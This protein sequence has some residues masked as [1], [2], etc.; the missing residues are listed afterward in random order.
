MTMVA[1]ARIQAFLALG[2]LG[3]GTAHGQDRHLTPSPN[4][5]VYTAML[6]SHLRANFDDIH[7]VS[8]R[9]H[10]RD[11]RLNGMIV[12]DMRWEG[13]RMTSA[14]VAR[15]ETG[16]R[17]FADAMVTR[18]E[19]WRVEGLAGPLETS[20]PLRIRIVGSDD[21]TFS[22]KGILTG[23]IRDRG[24]APLRDA[25]VRLLSPGGARDTL[26]AC[27]SNREGVF[28]KTLI[29]AGTWDLECRAK[30]FA[31]VV[32]CR[33]RFEPGEHVRKAIT[34]RRLE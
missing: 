14:S 4:D 34:L 23:V 7:D 13:G 15:N 31:P 16:S 5:S 27:Y 22:R 19:T 2:L 17:E 12:I 21:S 26:R 20:L 10:H 33:L 30:G 9:F 18:L 28:V 6:F 1:V 25:A 8:M 29:P 3:L 11:H 24:G 32:L